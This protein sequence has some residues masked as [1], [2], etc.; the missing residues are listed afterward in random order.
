MSLDRLKRTTA[1]VDIDGRQNGTAFLI[2]RNHVATALHVLNGRKQVDLVF[3]EWPI[4]A[5]TRIGTL[6]WQDLDDLDIAILELNRECPADIDPMPWVTKPPSASDEWTSWG[7]PA[8]VLNGHTMKGTVRDPRL[9]IERW[10]LRILQ[11][12][13]PDARDAISGMSGAPCMISGSLVGVLTHQL[14]RKLTEKRKEIPQPSFNAVYALPISL[15]FAGP[16]APPMFEDEDVGQSFDE[17]IRMAEMLAPEAKA[18]VLARV[19]RALDRAG[20]KSRKRLKL[21]EKIAHRLGA[22]TRLVVHIVWRD[23][24]TEAEALAQTVYRRL[25]RSSMD[26]T[27]PGLRVPTF[28]HNRPS[29]LGASESRPIDP[30]RVERSV[31]LLL[32][33][34]AMFGDAEWRECH[35]RIAS[36]SE[37]DVAGVSLLPAAVDGPKWANPFRGLYVFNLSGPEKEYRLLVALE[38]HLLGVLMRRPTDS[39]DKKYA[40][41][42]VSY[43][44]SDGDRFPSAIHDLANTTGK[45]EVLVDKGQLRPGD[46]FEKLLKA[47]RD[48]VFVAFFTASYPGRPWCRREMLEA[49]R[50]GLPIVVVDAQDSHVARLFPYGG[51][52]PSVKWRNDDRL[53]V[54]QVLEAA[55]F[56]ALRDKYARLLLDDH[57]LQDNS[58]RSARIVTRAPELLD[59][60]EGGPLSGLASLSSS[61]VILH[62][63]PPLS[64]EE[65]QV[66]RAAVPNL[67]VVSPGLALAEAGPLRKA[68]SGLPMRIALSA[69]PPDVYRPGIGI[70]HF[71]DAW[72]DLIRMLLLGGAYLD[73]GG[74]LRPGGLTDLLI[75]V[76][77]QRSDFEQRGARKKDARSERSTPIRSYLAWPL[78]FALK[79]RSISR[80]VDQV[81]FLKFPPPS[82]NATIVTPPSVPPKD[83]AERYL[84][85]RSLTMMRC[86]VVGNV[87]SMVVVG[88][89]STGFFGRYAGVVEE[90]LLAIKRNNP[91]FVLGG[92]GGAAAEVGE[93]LLGLTPKR[94]TAG[95]QPDCDDERQ[96]V[97]Y[98]NARIRNEA[99]ADEPAP[100][101]HDAVIQE[102][103]R[104]GKSKPNGP[105]DFAGLNNGLSADENKLLLTSPSLQDVVPVLMKGLQGLLRLK[106]STPTKPR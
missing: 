12:E 96:W 29:F 68:G 90:I 65:Q 36:L 79:D 27:S 15:L 93:A 20:I 18:S 28:L 72:L 106:G 14:Y 75:Q 57:A 99:K 74:D 54:H 98:Y 25:T 6:A 9:H 61:S 16:V 84:L 46:H 45:V 85:A 103:N 5:R 49:K 58:L 11:L 3:P 70:M 40:R 13:T 38:I 67:R 104:A 64:E 48:T 43:A 101:D 35:H 50:L 78:H 105:I 69:S 88:G 33:D 62:P 82:T 47:L 71:D 24:N 39:E 10:N 22:A 73:F 42:F 56:E 87:D 63:D 2:D 34:E 8:K 97:E 80:F 76:A 77:E 89:R 59:V 30:A 83:S 81:E 31:I 51:N 92:L 37:R 26:D 19:L 86:A 4:R 21:R 91:V 1:R 17:M 53:A 55:T 52:V 95:F 66:L 60:V 41:I 23:G 94:L 102:L 7:F 44:V 32:L 100:I